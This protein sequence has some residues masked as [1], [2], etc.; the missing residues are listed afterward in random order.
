MQIMNSEEMRRAERDKGDEIDKPVRDHRLFGG[1][2]FLLLL[3]R[4]FLCH[5]S[6]L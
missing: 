5:I 2:M 3:F 1:L 6:P 4:L